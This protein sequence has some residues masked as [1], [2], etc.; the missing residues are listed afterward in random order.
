VKA[1]VTGVVGVVVALA[2]ASPAAAKPAV[3]ILQPSAPSTGPVD[4]VTPVQQWPALHGFSADVTDTQRKR[5]AADP[6][7]AIVA[8]DVPVAMAGAA[9]PAAGGDLVPPGIRRIGAATAA[10]VHGAAGSAVALL[11]TGADLTNPDLNVA[12]GTNC[13]KPGT[14]PKDDNGHGTNV[15]GILAARNDGE[16]VVGVAPGT[17]IYAVKVLDAKGAGTLSQ[18]LCG[19]DWVTA[20]A[21]ALGIRVANMS[22]SGTGANDN[23]CGTVKKDAEHQAI[24][25]VTQ[26][27]VTIVAAAGNAAK[28]FSTTIPAAY[29]EVLT[30]TAMTD[31]DGM[32][33]GKGAPPACRKSEKDDTAG[34]Y[35]NYAATSADAGH[36]I[37]AP[38]TCVVSDKPGGGTSTYYGTSQAAPHVAGAVALCLDGPCAGLAPAGVLARVIG[39]GATGSFISPKGRLYGPLVTAAAY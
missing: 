32:A 7:V 24:C 37:A 3:V 26:A 36:I 1:W 21:A 16:G 34:T 6:S 25:R 33:G 20:N 17:A 28:S 27:G 8:D 29:P 11:D 39:D 14:A 22:I 18:L 13:V 31:T 35:S 2:A 19:L 12:G 9:V 38:G 4:G 5:L 30:A 15:A 23:A 10:L